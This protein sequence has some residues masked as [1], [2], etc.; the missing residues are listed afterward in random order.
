ML[1]AGDTCEIADS[2]L[3]STCQGIGCPWRTELPDPDGC[4]GA[5]GPGMIARPVTF[6]FGAACGEARIGRAAPGR[7]SG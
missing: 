1:A 6:S 7:R 5:S 4:R 3:S 2:V